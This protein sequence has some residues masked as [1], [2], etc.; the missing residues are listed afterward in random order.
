[1]KTLAFD[2]A[3]IISGFATVNNGEV[4]DYGCISVDRT[5]GLLERIENIKNN[6]SV[7]V[8]KYNPDIVALEDVQL[9]KNPDTFKALS[10]LLGIIE[11]YLVELEV[12]CVVIPCNEWRKGLGIKGRT[13][14]DKKRA[15]I[16]YVKYV[17]NIDIPNDDIA[18]A[19]CI[20]VYCDKTV[21]E[22]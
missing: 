6:I 16:N 1:M 22:G 11:M 21:K 19:I 17:L 14:E 7:L 8:D 5:I 9:Q 15:A 10:K 12:P 2:Q 18:E 4:E 20:G 13:R 3:T